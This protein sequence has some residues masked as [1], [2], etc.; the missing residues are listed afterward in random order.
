MTVQTTKN[1]IVKDL[2]KLSG[3]DNL[4]DAV[5]FLNLTTTGQGVD[6]V[7]EEPWHRSGSETYLTVFTLLGDDGARKL[8][9]KACVPGAATIPVESILSS[10]VSKRSEISAGFPSKIT[11]RLF[12]H[13]SGVIL[14]EY[15]E[16]TLKEMVSQNDECAIAGADLIMHIASLGFD[17]SLAFSDFRSRGYDAVI[18]DF[19]QDLG[20]KIKSARVPLESYINFLRANYANASA[21]ESVARRLN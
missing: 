13:G 3:K 9:L 6:I 21:I 18:V 14:E 19:G 4:S 7:V 12:S 8:V 2:L 16:Y 15:I 17:A 10:W 1:D 11:P 5:S 20:S